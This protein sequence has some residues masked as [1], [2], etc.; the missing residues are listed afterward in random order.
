M[1]QIWE[2]GKQEEI[3]RRLEKLAS[4]T[5]PA[6][7][8]FTAARMLD[9]CAA[10]MRAGLGDFPVAAKRTPFRNWP[11]R[12]LVIYALPWPKGAPTAPELLPEGEPDF[13]KAGAD[14]RSAL[15]R[16]AAAGAAGKF[17]DHAAFG[18][19][20]GVEWGAL[21]YRH[22]DHHWKQFRL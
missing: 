15:K 17:A 7:G 22:L 9:H 13:E 1:P 4:D 21:T 14:L 5:K 11:M 12:K 3:L 16:F 19:L 20:S 6:W 2:S 8:K 18:T 10:A